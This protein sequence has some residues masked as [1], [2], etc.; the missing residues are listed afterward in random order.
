MTR[1]SCAETSEAINVTTRYALG[2][3]CQEQIGT[4]FAFF[5]AFA[6]DVTC[7]DAG[8]LEAQIIRA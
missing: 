2:V 5:P 6:V 3:H 1:Y 8:A 7:A 4:Y